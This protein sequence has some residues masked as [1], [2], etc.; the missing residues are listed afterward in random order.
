[1]RGGLDV[2][3]AGC[4]VAGL[5]L[6][7]LL[8][9]A[10]WRVTIYDRLE[11]PAPL[12]SGLIL[13]PVG[14]AVLAKLGLA[15]RA[16]ELGARI[17]RLFGRVLPTDR[18]VLDVRYRALDPLSHGIGVHRGALFEILFA[19]AVAAGIAFE[20]HRD[21]RAVKSGRFQFADGSESAHFHLLVDAL[22]VRSPLSPK[23]GRPLAYGALW[24]SLDWP[25]G[26]GFDIHA[27]EQRYVAARRMVGVL[28]IGR[29]GE[30]A[31][32]QAAFF[33]S[34]KGGDLGAWR[35]TSIDVWKDE[36]RSV[37]PQTEPFLAQVKTHN[38]LV[39]ANYAHRTLAT[40]LSRGI[41]HVGDSFRCTSPQLGQGANM[42]LL[43]AFALSHALTSVR[44]L[45]EALEAYARMRLTHTQLYQLASWLF[46]PVYQSDSSMLPFLRDWIA[47]PLSRIPPVPQILAALV[48]GAIGSPLQAI[49]A[50]PMDARA[51]TMLPSADVSS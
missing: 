39:F 29:L 37:W 27:L 2:G 4:G 22:G 21:V 28:P 42:A 49:G 50:E 3:I 51:A 46:T 1:M 23:A 9:K 38:D 12:G 17:D 25:D 8:A 30:Q 36:V 6:G 31:P 34:L 33:W 13:Q 24:A 19:A 5:A 18:V 41:V 45:D 10:G 11:K 26:G 48:T 15:G 43:D 44:G 35:N 14:M 16:R 47:G 7:T 40:P 32:Q 20:P